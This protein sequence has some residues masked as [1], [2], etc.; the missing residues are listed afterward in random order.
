M[1]AASSALSSNRPA[2]PTNTWPSRSS[3]SPGCSPTIISRAA[4]I[5][6]SPNT[7][8]VAPLYRS[9]PR[10]SAAA[11][12]NAAQ[13]FPSGTNWAAE[14]AFLLVGLEGILDLLAGL[15]DVGLRALGTALSLPLLV[16]R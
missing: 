10:Q 11:E 15:L 6:P 4:R 9:H 1:P 5:G 7:V 3:W 14:A 13:P 16:V 2:G 12:R 8:W